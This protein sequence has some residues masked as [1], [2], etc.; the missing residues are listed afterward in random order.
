MT[1]NLPPFS[2]VVIMSQGSTDRKYYE[3][4]EPPQQRGLG[5]LA[6]GFLCGAVLMIAAGAYLFPVLHNQWNA[7]DRD[8]KL[9]EAEVKARAEADA[10]FRKTEARIKAEGQA[11]GERLAKLDIAPTAFTAVAEKA[12][13][14]VVNLSNIMIGQRGAT[15]VGEGSGV[16]Y[17][18]E[19]DADGLRVGY[20]VTNSHVVRN[21]TS[22]SRYDLADRIGITFASGRTIYVENTAIY[23][24][25]GYDLAVIKFDAADFDDL[26]A[27]DFGNSDDVHVGDW[28]V[29]IGSPFGL[30]QSVT[31]GILSAKG[32]R[33]LTL[34]ETEVLQTDA[35][36]NQ[37]NSGG[38]LLNLKGQVIGINVAIATA[39]QTTGNLGV[40]FAI[41]STTVHT[42]VEE[43]LKPPHRIVRGFLGV[44]PIDLDPRDAR[45]FHVKG[46]AI[47]GRVVDGSPAD[48]AGLK[49]GDI[50]VGV[51]YQGKEHEVLSAEQLRSLIREIKPEERVVLGIIRGAVE[52]EELQRLQIEVV[53]GELPPEVEMGAPAQ[54]DPFQVPNPFN[55]QPFPQRRR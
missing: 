53:I 1:G 40:A 11:A 23:H 44:T 37:G 35:A 7:F 52:K 46:G 34:V 22:R 12:G 41:P 54:P 18:F 39:G 50:V 4:Q 33:D 27:A 45:R 14:A 38:P 47:L 49:L 21:L 13:P 8:T 20:V 16:I 42:I 25:P 29:A 28:V 17:K 5:G 36:V 9:R 55:R 43:L 30:K 3:Y 51:K 26:V 32:R 2:R 24:D 6:F 19:K 15:K 31:A 10:E 48:K